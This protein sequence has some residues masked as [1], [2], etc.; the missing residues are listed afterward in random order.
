MARNNNYNLTFAFSLL[1]LA[2]ML[3]CVAKAQAPPDPAIPS[4]SSP[5][6]ADADCDSGSFC[7]A[8]FCGAYVTENDW[9]GGFLPPQDERRCLPNLVCADFPTD[10]LLSQDGNGYCRRQCT[11]TADCDVEGSFC[12]ADGM[13]RSAGSCR[14][15]VDCFNADNAWVRTAC[16]GPVAC[17]NGSCAVH[18]SRVLK[19]ASAPL[20][21]ASSA[22]KTLAIAKHL[23]ASSTDEKV[24]A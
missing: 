1:I 11:S 7:R 19:P 21:S 5:C 4:S 9:C 6:E 23:I 13:C 15:A 2:T 22:S 10:P 24:E 14:S 17:D 16:L 8:G 12:A 20:V 3:T 18:C